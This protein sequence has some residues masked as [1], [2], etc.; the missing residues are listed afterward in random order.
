MFRNREDAAFQLAEAL[1]R[2]GKPL[3]DPIVLA[4]PRGGVVTG[5]VVAQELGADLDV[6]L[7]RKLRAPGQ[8]EAAIGAIAEDGSV[9]L[10][11]LAEDV[12]IA[13]DAYLT[14]ERAHQ[15]AEIQRRKS[16]FRGIRPRASLAGRSVIL[17][18]DGIATGATILAALRAIE[19]EH[20]VEVIVATPVACP[21]SLA[22][23]RRWCDE[24]VCL[25]VPRRFL[26]VGQYYEDF[27]PIEDEQVCHL[28]RAFRFAADRPKEKQ[29]ATT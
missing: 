6:M 23:V 20:P 4:I 14:T 25:S 12:L 21:R 8:P 15:L 17:V 29:P 3:Q 9:Y 22:E 10:D 28:L 16:L 18:D 27:A 19:G 11:P 2:R 5:A 7:A 1:I 26:A 24:V 13:N